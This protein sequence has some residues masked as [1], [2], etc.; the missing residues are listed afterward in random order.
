[1][2]GENTPGGGD[3]RV[4]SVRQ[5]QQKQRP[6]RLTIVTSPPRTRQPPSPYHATFFLRAR[7]SVGEACAEGGS[8]PLLGSGVGKAYRSRK[9][10]RRTSTRLPY[11]CHPP[12]KKKR[13]KQTNQPLSASGANKAQPRPT[14]IRS[15]Q[16]KRKGLTAAAAAPDAAPDP[17]ADP[18][19]PPA[20]RPPSPCA[21]ASPHSLR[22]SP[23]HG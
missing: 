13:R 10:Q 6:S 1:M 14:R 3:H 12:L 9:E 5:Y 20:C 19:P 21:L 8:S 18:L 11:S 17:V 23:L 7:A 15:N 22:H 2:E 4:L 16:E